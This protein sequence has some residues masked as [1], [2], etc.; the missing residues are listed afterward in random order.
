MKKIV[1]EQYSYSSFLKAYTKAFK[2]ACDSR[3]LNPNYD[4]CVI[5]NQYMDEFEHITQR[6]NENFNT[7]RLIVKLPRRKMRGLLDTDWSDIYRFEEQ[8]DCLPYVDKDRCLKHKYIYDDYVEYYSEYITCLA[9]EFISK[10]DQIFIIPP[11][12][13][14]D[15]NYSISLLKKHEYIP[16]METFWLDEDMQE[17]LDED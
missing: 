5:T 2:A 3:L 6:I 1:L 8:N 11:E 10:N 4:E 13:S 9:Q 14:S 7:D 16:W 12:L 15:I 17:W